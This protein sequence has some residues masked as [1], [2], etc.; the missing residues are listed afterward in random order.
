MLLKGKNAII[1]GCARGI[2]KSILEMFAQN[3][4]NIWACCRKQTEEF[5]QYIQQ[6]G[7]NCGNVITPLYFDLLNSEQVKIAIKKILESRQKVDVL[8]NNAG[9]TYNSL[10]QMTTLEKMK[11]VFEVNFFSQMLLTQYVAKIMIKNKG[12]SIINISSTAGLDGNSGRSAY[13]A[14]KAAVICATKAIAAELA[15]YGIR[16]N[17]VAP[18][19]TRTDMV[20]SS[21]SDKVIQDTI[22]QTNLKRMGQPSEIANAVLFLASDLSTYVTGQVIRVDGGLQ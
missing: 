21:M 5:E 2:G 3:G 15:E 22:L 6:L 12:G 11:E 8:V 18:G 16:T 1:T 17:S 4:A 10:F 14:S 13:G 9:I 20:A 7:K 19:I